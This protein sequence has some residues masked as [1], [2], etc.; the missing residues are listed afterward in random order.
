MVCD[1]RHPARLDVFERRTR[2]HREAKEEDV[3]LGVGERAQTVVVLLSCLESGL[4][5]A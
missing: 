4:R 3:G 1:L 2:D 5:F